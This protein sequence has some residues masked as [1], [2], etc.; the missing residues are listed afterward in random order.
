MILAYCNT[1]DYKP[2]YKNKV[3]D[4]KVRVLSLFFIFFHF[5]RLSIDLFKA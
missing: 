1:L 2:K 4:L 3:V 5:I